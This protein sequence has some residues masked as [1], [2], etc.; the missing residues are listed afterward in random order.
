MLLVIRQISDNK[1]FFQRDRA[2]VPYDRK[3]IHLLGYNSKAADLFVCP[4]SFMFP[5][6]VESSPLQFL[7]LA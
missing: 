2:P 5:W 3:T 6:A 4:H 1:F 7:A